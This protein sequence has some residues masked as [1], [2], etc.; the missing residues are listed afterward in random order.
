[1][2][3]GAGFYDWTPEVRQAERERYDRLLRQGLQLLAADLP[4]IDKSF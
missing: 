4:P 2:K 1:M 3:S